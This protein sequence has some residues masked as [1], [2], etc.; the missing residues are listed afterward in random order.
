MI[1]KAHRSEQYAHI[2][3]FLSPYLRSLSHPTEALL[4]VS[5]ARSSLS[6]IRWPV[7]L[8][9]YLISFYITDRPEDK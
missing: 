2:R 3:S 9:D 4:Q 6:R 5:L 8:L 7:R 1:A